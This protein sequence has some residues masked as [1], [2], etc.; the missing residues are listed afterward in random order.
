MHMPS[1]CSW[2]AGWEPHANSTLCMPEQDTTEPEQ[3]GFG[4]GTRLVSH[5]FVCTGL[6]SLWLTAWEEKECVCL[7]NTLY[8]VQPWLLLWETLLLCALLHSLADLTSSL[9]SSACHQATQVPHLYCLSVCW[10]ASSMTT[11]TAFVIFPLWAPRGWPTT[12]RKE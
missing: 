12:S 6:S 1:L 3:M 5:L 4:E 10:D 9:L 2:L 7:Q 8:I 11:G